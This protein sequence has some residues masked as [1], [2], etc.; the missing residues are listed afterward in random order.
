[1][2]IDELT[3]LTVVLHACAYTAPHCLVG[4][5][6]VAIV[7]RTGR[8]EVHVSAVSGMLRREYMVEGSQ[9]VVVGIAGLRVATVHVFGKFQHIVGVAR[10]RTINVIDEVRTGLL[11]GEVLPARVA[12]KGQ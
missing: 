8:R 2:G 5:R 11:A 6:V 12:S 9:F 1:M 3:V 10:L 7:T 4:C